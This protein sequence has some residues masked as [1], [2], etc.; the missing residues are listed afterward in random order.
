MC[1]VCLHTP[2]DPACPNAEEPKPVYTCKKCGEGIYAGEKV[3]LSPEGPICQPCMKKM[4]LNDILSLFGEELE[5]PRKKDDLAIYLCG[6]CH[7]AI[8]HGT[9]MLITPTGPVCRECLEEMPVTKLISIFGEK[10][11]EAGEE[12]E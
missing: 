11:D 4:G 3:F 9:Q 5:T 8:Y 6:E 1:S 7:R 12:L 10:M 2:C